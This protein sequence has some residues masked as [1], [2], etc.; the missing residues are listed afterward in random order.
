[1]SQPATV[2]LGIEKIDVQDGLNPRTRF[3]ETTRGSRPPLPPLFRHVG[4]QRPPA[5]RSS[6][7]KY[8]SSAAIRFCSSP[9]R[10]TCGSVLNPKL[11]RSA[12]MGGE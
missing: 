9:V 12:T 5:K 2:V 6:P 1:M 10:S 8:G 11:P 4:A 3:D 7:P